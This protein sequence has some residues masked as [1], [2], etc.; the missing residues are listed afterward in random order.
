MTHSDRPEVKHIARGGI[1]VFIG[2]V[3]GGVLGLALHVLLSRKLGAHDYGLYMLGFSVF[4]IAHCALS[5]GLGRGILRFVAMHKGAA[6]GARLRGTLVFSFAISTGACMVGAL[7]LYASSDRIAAAW[8]GKP[9]F[10]M[11]LRI[12]AI[13]LPFYNVLLSSCFAIQAFGRMGAY[14]TLR[15]VLIP[16]VNLLLASVLLMLW[17]FDLQTAL[18]ASLVT[19]ALLAGLGLTYVTLAARGVAS[20]GRATIEGRNILRYSLP[21]LFAG[22]AYIL[23]SYVDRIM[24]GLFEESAAIGLYSVSAKVA[25]Q[26]KVA[27]NCI[28]AVLGPVIADLSHRG[29]MA[30]VAS[31]FRTSTRWIVIVILPVVFVCVAFGG[32]ILGLFGAEFSGGTD[33]LIVLVSAYTVAAGTG[34][35]GVIL[36]MTGKQDIELINTLCMVGL[37]IVLNL[38]LIQEYGIMGA[39][40]A[41][42]ASIALVNLVKVIEVRLFFGFQPYD[43][44]FLKPIATAAIILLFL[45]IMRRHFALTGWLWTLPC[46]GSA[47]A[48]FGILLG[49]GL[50]DDDRQVLAAIR[51]RLG[52]KG[53]Q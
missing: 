38:W 40:I 15:N 52:L 24:I 6:D 10:G 9:E 25:V 21:L 11:V 3:A 19:M 48:Y 33:V 26:T 17:R 39:A 42:G 8:F 1:I 45:L 35:V 16:A 53:L 31:M 41:T 20:T 18:Y 49:L 44:T 32:E 28:N 36:N 27:L 51:R 4:V 2:T 47:A 7:L 43:R 50:E 22:M 46:I 37:N 34:S 12:Y 23:L 5:L 29:D 13:A 14:S 30:S